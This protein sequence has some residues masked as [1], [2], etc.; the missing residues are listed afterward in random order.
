[1]KIVELQLYRSRKAILEL[2]RKLGQLALTPRVGSIR[3]MKTCFKQ[4]LK[5]NAR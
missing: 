1:M 5:M 4:W 3:E 2:E